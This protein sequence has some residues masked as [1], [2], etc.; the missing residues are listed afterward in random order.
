MVTR[1]LFIVF[2]IFAVAGAGYL[3]ARYKRPDIG[4]ANQLNMDLF[5][6]A[7]IFHV[8]AGRTFD[9]GAYAYLALGGLLVVV[10][11]GLLLLPLVRPLG[12]QPKTFIPPMMFTNSG[13]L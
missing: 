7:L 2:P 13:N 1:I 3:Y 8:L 12:V 6:P 4:V 11:S 5:L 10:G 9:L